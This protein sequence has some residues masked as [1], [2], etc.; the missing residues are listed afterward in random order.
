MLIRQEIPELNPRNIRIGREGQLKR[1]YPV[2]PGEYF[3]IALD[4]P[5]VLEIE[6]L[7]P[8]V[9]SR[10]VLYS[11]L[12]TAEDDWHEIEFTKINEQKH[13][14]SY[15]L[16]LCGMFQFKV[17]YSLD[18][19][20]H[21]F[22]DRVPLTHVL[23]D[24][25]RIND[26]RMYT[27]LPTVSG[28]LSD[29]N[30]AL[31][32]IHKMHFNM[33][34]LLPVTALS[35]SGSP[36]SA[37]DYFS[38]DPTY[39]DEDEKA[40]GL[41]QFEGFVES[42]KKLGIGL[43]FDLVLNHVGLSSKIVRQCPEW[44]VPDKNETNG[45]MRPGCWHMNNWI[46]WSDLVKID[47]DHPQEDMRRNI[48]SYMSQYAHFWAGYADYTGGMV[49]LDNLHSSHE[50]FMREL[51]RDLRKAYPQ[52]MVLAEFFTDSNTLSNKTLDLGLN[53]LLA[54]AWE[55]P[56]AKDLRAYIVYI[57]RIGSKLRFFMPVTTHDTGAP[58][59]LFGG[60]EA[61]VPRYFITALFGTGQTGIV[62]GVEHGATER[63]DFIGRNLT[64]GRLDSDR[65]TGI[66]TK[67]NSLQARMPAFHAAGNLTFIDN[68]HGAVLGAFRA[69]PKIAG[70]GIILFANLD[71][72]GGHALQID[73]DGIPGFPSDCRLVDQLS[74]KTL[75]VTNGHMEFEIEP[76]GIH[77]FTCESQ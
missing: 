5:L 49:R 77:A 24:P 35:D 27:L 67:I 15:P 59:Q 26:I 40:D 4:E 9:D 61:V 71:T 68:H 42:A 36:Y 11:N 17:K 13:V 32:N 33:I 50:G 2:A 76:C 39:L 45:L 60:P 55:Y 75:T 54:N 8:A 47:Y 73:L 38:I 52:L 46:R 70:K 25:P 64:M 1:S 41:T 57:H 7:V 3:R 21:W 34:H 31:T 43:C 19:G 56:Y 63:I 12:K 51:I 23:V 37:E 30:D 72:Q 16:H 69:E 28:R 6:F 62:Q 20:K 29:W 53:L 22:W 14:L 74:D 48:W 58:A 66:I 65:Y 18:N 10:V 44:I